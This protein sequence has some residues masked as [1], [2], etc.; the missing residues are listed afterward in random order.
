MNERCGNLGVFPALRQLDCSAE[1]TQESWKMYVDFQNFCMKTTIDP[2]PE[3]KPNPLPYPTA[4]PPS[5]ARKPYVPS[6]TKSRPGIPV[7]NPANEPL[8]D[9]WPNNSPHKQYV[10]P[11]ERGRRPFRRFLQICVLGGIGY[12]LFTKRHLIDFSRFSRFRTSMT[13]VRNFYPPQYNNYNYGNDSGGDDSGMYESLTLTD[14]GGSSSFQPPTLPPGPS[15]YGPS[16]T[17]A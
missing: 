11:E 15:A 2:I 8:P 9:V 16:G 14:M 13:R 3:S 4:P 6:E 1:I 10:P 12:L 5:P 7:I 17:V